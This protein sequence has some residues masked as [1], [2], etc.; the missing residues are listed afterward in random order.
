MLIYGTFYGLFINKLISMKSKMSTYSF[1]IAFT[2]LAISPA[3]SQDT[4]QNQKLTEEHT[5]PIR[6]NKRKYNISGKRHIYRDTRL[7]GSSPYFNTY[8]KN[9]YGAGAITTDP[10]KGM[11]MAHYPAG[12]FDS[13]NMSN[14]M[15]S[16]TRLGGSSPGHRTYQS[17]DYGAGAITTNPHKDNSSGRSSRNISYPARDSTKK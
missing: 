9:D 2:I 7:G 14:K 15:H 1:V 8:Q 17:N 3:F 12:Q 4:S 6:P 11:G 13:S 10:N 16:E 5:Y